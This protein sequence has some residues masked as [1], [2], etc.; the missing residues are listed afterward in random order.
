VSLSC[1][2]TFAAVAREIR[3][4]VND[5]KCLVDDDLKL[6]HAGLFSLS[7]RFEPNHQYRRM[8]ELVVPKNN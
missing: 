7:V 4:N 8:L 5:I 6:N 2:A 3:E 1:L